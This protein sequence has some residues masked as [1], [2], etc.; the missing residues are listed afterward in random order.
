MFILYKAIHGLLY[1][2]HKKNQFFCENFEYFSKRKPG[3]CLCNALVLVSYSLYTVYTV[4]NA[5][6]KHLQ[7]QLGIQQ[8][9]FNVAIHFING[10]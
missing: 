8:T 2:F 10:R 9:G 5:G 3:Q 6:N 4:L 7:C 1:Y